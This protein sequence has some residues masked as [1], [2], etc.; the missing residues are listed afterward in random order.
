MAVEKGTCTLLIFCIT[1]LHTGVR[2]YWDRYRYRAAGGHVLLPCADMCISDC[3]NTVW[4]YSNSQGQKYE[5]M[6]FGKVRTD[7]TKRAE[8][9]SPDFC[10]RLNIVNVT[11]EDAGEYYCGPGAGEVYLHV[12][13]I[14]EPPSISNNGTDGDVT[15][16]C[17]LHTHEGCEKV[18]SNNRIHLSW[19]DEEASTLQENADHQIQ[20]IS[21]CHTTLKESHLH[22]REK[23]WRCQLTTRW[24]NITATYTKFDPT[25][26]LE[27]MTESDKMGK[28]RK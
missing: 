11:A 25:G 19:I 15:L 3:H 2:G 17:I 21:T 18:S 6:T 1:I 5:V 4:T 12:L 14:S 20:N 27:L 16:S 26:G 9:M 10:C 28:T 24:H 7:N 8:R 22:Q 13:E 23:T